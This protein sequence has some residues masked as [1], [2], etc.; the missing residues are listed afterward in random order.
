[1][2]TSKRAALDAVCLASQKVDMDRSTADRFKAP[3]DTV[4]YGHSLSRLDDSRA[5]AVAAGATENEI[6]SS[7]LIGQSMALKVVESSKPKH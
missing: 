2:E 5:R 6:R 4:D 1:M 7:E 3:T